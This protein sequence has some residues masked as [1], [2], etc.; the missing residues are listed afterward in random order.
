MSQ[1]KEYDWIIIGGGI[2]GCY[3]SLE[4]A[5]LG[6]RVALIEK[7]STLISEAS[8][9]NQARIHLGYH[10]PRSFATA[11][12]SAEYFDRFCEDFDFAI[13]KSFTKIYA[14]AS[15]FS[16]SS[17]D[18]FKTFC[19]NL[20]IPCDPINKERYFN[21]EVEAAFETK[22]Y[23]FDAEI[24]KDYYFKELSA[25]KNATLYLNSEL[26]SISQEVNLFKITT[27]DN[28]N[29]SAN[30]LLNA[31]YANTNNILKLL[32]LDTFEIK[33]E[34]CEVILCNVSENIKKV[35]LT[36]MDGPFFS[37]MPFGYSGYHSLTSVIFTP[38][39]T[40]VKDE[41]V[42]KGV[43]I[44]SS[45]DYMR[46][47]THRYLNPEIKIDYVRSLYTVKPILKVSESDDSRPTIVKKLNSKPN[48]YTVFS[49]KINTIYD[50]D[51]ILI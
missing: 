28:Y 13:N 48:F 23:T 3:A 9:T 25:N 31:T 21:S 46:N 36:V 16:Y 4:L 44:V 1:N 22:E 51:N 18:N 5:N 20:N 43:N 40:F 47:L 41:E 32:N 7:N 26:I 34:M 38:H 6:Y 27:S 15:N 33:Y 35:G 50:L 12:K 29:L 17:G 37:L 24:I 42:N 10:Y 8:Y 30:N 19:K 45:W 39:Y 2:Y 11:Y 14:I 49:G